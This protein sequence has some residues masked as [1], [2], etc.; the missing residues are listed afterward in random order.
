MNCRIF[1]QGREGTIYQYLSS[2]KIR[3][4][5]KWNWSEQSIDIVAIGIVGRYCQ[6]LYRNQSSGII[7]IVHKKGNTSFSTYLLLDLPT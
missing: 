4:S 1:G 5:I 6:T 3:Q 2:W 7:G